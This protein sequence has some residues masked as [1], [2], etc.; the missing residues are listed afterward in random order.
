MVFGQ[1]R[2]N[3][4]NFHRFLEDQAEK[5]KKDV[6]VAAA[7]VVGRWQSGAPVILTPDKDDKA[8]GGNDL[9]NNYFGFN[10]ALPSIAEYLREEEFLPPLPTPRESAALPTPISG[11]QIPAI[12]SRF[13]PAT[14]CAIGCFGA[15]FRTSTRQSSPRLSPQ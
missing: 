15:A 7:R 14:G 4:G 6:G 8:L 10:D 3:V 12:E 1:F 11:R 2:Q 5:L 13:W 9:V